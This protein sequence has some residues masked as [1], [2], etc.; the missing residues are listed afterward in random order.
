[1]HSVATTS[2]DRAVERQVRQALLNL[3]ADVLRLRSDA[4]ISRA[5]LARASGIDVSFLREIETGAA[6]PLVQTCMRLALALGADFP[7]R[8]YPATGPTVRDRHQAAIAEV[9]LKEAGPR[10]RA[11]SS[12]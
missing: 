4:G 6:S 8:L 5:A 7:L 2:F 10:W 1:M 9:T 11:A 12:S 3:G